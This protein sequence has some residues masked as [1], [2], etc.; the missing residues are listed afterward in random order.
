M[1]TTARHALAQTPPLSL[2]L[3]EHQPGQRRRSEHSSYW[4]THGSVP[5]L[6]FLFI[7]TYYVLCI[8]Y[9]VSSIVCMTTSRVSGMEQWI[10]LTVATIGVLCV[11]VHVRREVLRV[12]P[13]F[14]PRP[15]TMTTRVV[16][17]EV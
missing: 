8:A 14:D 16:V 13:S 1:S 4:S 2:E 12:R 11:R 3:Q 17:L 7:R 5:A 6:Y 15:S 10:M 9:F